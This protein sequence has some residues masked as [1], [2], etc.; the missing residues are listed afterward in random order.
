MIAH[1][2]F[3]VPGAG[4]EPARPCGHK[5]FVPT[6]AF[7]AF[8]FLENFVVWT[9]PSPYSIRPMKRRCLPSSLYTFSKLLWTLARDCH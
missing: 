4:L 5:I 3:F 6:T 1:E 7:A 2:G 9:F 8:L